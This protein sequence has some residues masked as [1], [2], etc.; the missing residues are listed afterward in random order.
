V[1]LTD[2]KEKTGTLAAQIL[3]AISSVNELV[4]KAAQ[5]RADIQYLNGL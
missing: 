5:T 2:L 3:P 4:K 1:A